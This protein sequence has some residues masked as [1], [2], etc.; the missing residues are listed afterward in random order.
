MKVHIMLIDDDKD[1]LTFFLDALKDVPCDEGFK[2]TYAS[3]TKQA[4]EMLKY[5]VPDFIFVDFKMPGIN[6]LQ[7]LLTIKNR[8]GSEK[9]KVY[10]YSIFINEK[11]KKAALS[12]GV[13]GT[14]KKMFTIKSL[15]DELKAVLTSPVTP[16]YVFSGG[17]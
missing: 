2:C 3:D 13:S 4:A 6:G 8:L 10:L 15:S 16:A 7:F 17:E 1:E 12:L 14:L 11:I 9:P 5:L